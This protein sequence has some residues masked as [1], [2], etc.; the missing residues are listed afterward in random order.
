MFNPDSPEVKGEVANE[1]N[2]TLRHLL[3]KSPVEAEP[4]A[5]RELP[6]FEYSPPTEPAR[7]ARR[8]PITIGPSRQERRQ[9]FDL[10]AAGDGAS[11]APATGRPLDDRQTPVL[12]EIADL[13]R[14]NNRL[15][16]QAA[17][18]TPRDRDRGPLSVARS[19]VADRNRHVE[20]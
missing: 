11:L 2:R 7:R 3:P 16:E 19:A 18:Q 4:R 20:G 9:S 1:M 10:P 5:I 15:Q 6:Q 14:R 12:Q 17:N 8:M 13:M